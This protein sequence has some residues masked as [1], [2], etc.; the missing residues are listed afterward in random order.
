MGVAQVPERVV[1]WFDDRQ[2][3][4]WPLAFAIG[5]VRKYADDRGSAL[6]GVVTFHVFLGMLPVL[7]VFL[8]LLG[9]VLEGSADLREAAL[10]SVLSELPVLG[11]RIAEDVSALTASGW[12]LVIAVVG[13]LWSATGIYTSLQYA[14]NQVWQVEGVHRQG[15]VSRQVRAL[16][17]FALVI[18]AA[19]GTAFLRML[20]VLRPSTRFLADL[21][22]MTAAVAIATVV[23]LGVHRLVVAPVVPLRRLLPAALVSAL[24]WELLQLIGTWLVVR[25]L[26]EADDLY[27]ALGF[28]VVMLGWINLLARSIIF[29]NAWATVSWRHLWPRRIAQPPL[30]EA[31]QRALEGLVGNERRR[32]EERT[33]VEFEEARDR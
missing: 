10:D 32:P 2:Q 18:L 15:F 1:R 6:A 8:T 13:L 25:R 22:S 33:T 7:V 21:L 23:L 3:E 28:V 11:D 17:L 14:L 24:L 31:D 4:L 19:V 30:T 16:L 9:L 26:G 27:G 20:P 12:V 29:A 5:V